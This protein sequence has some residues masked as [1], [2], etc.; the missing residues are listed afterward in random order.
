MKHNCPNCGAPVYLDRCSCPYCETA[1]TVGLINDIWNDSDFKML[2]RALHNGLI[3]SNEARELL[4]L[5]NVTETERL[6]AEAV[7]KMQKY[8]GLESVLYADDR[9]IAFAY[10]DIDYNQR[11]EMIR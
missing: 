11:L 2:M 5:S 1:Y 6:Y 7:M 8:S 4:S 9:P 3:T 10:M